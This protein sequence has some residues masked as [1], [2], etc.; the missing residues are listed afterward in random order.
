MTEAEITAL[1]T[2]NI[3]DNQVRYITAARL[4]EVLHALNAK[5]TEDPVEFTGD[6][7]DI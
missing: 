5:P 2:A 1:I 4:R 7:F 3:K 6:F